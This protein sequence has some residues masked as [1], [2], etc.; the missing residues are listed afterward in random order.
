MKA[1]KL[2]RVVPSEMS[3]ICQIF[4]QEGNKLSTFFRMFHIEMEVQ[5][6]TFPN[7]IVLIAEALLGVIEPGLRK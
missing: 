3:F 7:G 1:W 6:R 5:K 2:N 4:E